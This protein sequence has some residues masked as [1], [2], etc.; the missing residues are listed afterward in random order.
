ME[1]L[2]SY[3]GKFKKGYLGDFATE[4]WTEKDWEKHR[5]EV[6]EMKR[7]GTYGEEYEATITMS[8]HPILDIR[9][10]NGKSPLE[11]YGMIFLDHSL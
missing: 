4:W 3:T 9:I 11:S 5:K 7:D 2:R 8:Y 1:E 10:S 6:E